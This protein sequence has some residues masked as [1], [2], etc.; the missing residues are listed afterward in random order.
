MV[1]VGYG[2]KKFIFKKAGF[3]RDV[4][5]NG[6]SIELA[7]IGDAIANGQFNIPFL[8]SNTASA[9]SNGYVFA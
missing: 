5:S 8:S 3:A 4:I 2:L 1:L 6:Q 9:S 7:R